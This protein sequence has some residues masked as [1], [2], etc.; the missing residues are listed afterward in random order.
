MKKNTKIV[1]V[2]VYAVV[3]LCI[4]SAS[5]LMEP[6]GGNEDTELSG[7]W[8]LT[9]RE[10][11]DQDQSYSRN[12]DSKYDIDIVEKDNGMFTARSQ[13]VEFC[14]ISLN[15]SIV[16][17]YRYGDSTWIRADGNISNGK[18]KLYETH[19]YGEG[20]WFV[21]ISIYSKKDVPLK[22][23]SDDMAHI[24]STWNLQSGTSHLYDAG[25]VDNEIGYDLAGK[26]FFISSRHGALFRAEMQQEVDDGGDVHIIT[27][28][29]N[30][31]FIS[32]SIAFLLDES[33]KMWTLSV[34]NGLAVLRAIVLSEHDGFEGKM[35]V[36]QRTYYN[37][38]PPA[39]PDAPDMLGEWTATGAAGM[40][41]DGSDASR[42][43]TVTIDYKWQDGY[44]F[45]GESTSGL[46][47]MN[48]AGYIVYYPDAISNQFMIRLGTDLSGSF[49]EGY[50][51][52]NDD[53]D[54]MILVEFIYDGVKNGIVQY[55][56]VR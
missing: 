19:F 42:T 16:F 20:D 2:S 14:G 45:T 55:V 53:G 7:M 9:S 56:F 18:M 3:L 13:N 5:Y 10:S 49:R 37:G 54:E 52:L 22:E 12:I 32:D 35:V 39:V 27:R 48:E 40:N 51:F 31:V 30:G 47:S 36:T 26:R 43:D 15:G 1:I 41:G 50:A 24:Q 46:I 21:A 11:L 38:I 17:E 8:Y 25:E 28:L 6:S 29:M 33:G 34:Q 4:V 23:Y 44:I